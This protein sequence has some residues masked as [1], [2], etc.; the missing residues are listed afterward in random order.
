MVTFM[1]TQLKINYINICFP[2]NQKIF[3]SNEILKLKKKTAF[4]LNFLVHLQSKR[5]G[6]GEGESPGILGK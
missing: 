4:F 2:V 5:K 3:A 6:K 1:F